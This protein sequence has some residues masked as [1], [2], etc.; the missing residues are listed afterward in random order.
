MQGFRHFI[1]RVTAESF[2]GGPRGTIDQSAF[3]FCLNT[4]EAKNGIRGAKRRRGLNIKQFSVTI[5]GLKYIS[6]P[7]PPSSVP[8]P[9]IP[10][11]HVLLFSQFS[12]PLP[13]F[14]P[15]LSRSIFH[16]STE[17]VRFSGISSV[18]VRP[19]GNGTIASPLQSSSRSC[20]MHNAITDEVG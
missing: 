11:P 17:A 16:L 10:S 5:C 3:P 6:R 13:F 4:T 18:R 14:S 7:P 8:R 12:L 20:D 2:C 19:D 1:R 9:I 15:F